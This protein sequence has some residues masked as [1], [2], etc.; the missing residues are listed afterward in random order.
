MHIVVTIVG[1]LVVFAVLLDA[2]ET[3]VLPRRVRR[4]YRITSWF[5]RRT[6][7]PWRKITTHIKT[8]S[9]RENFLG[10]FGPLSL[11][12]LLGLWAA[13]LIFGFALLQYGAGEHVQLSGEPITF[14]RLLYHSGETFFTLGYG[15][16]VPTSPIARLLAVLEAGM[17]FGF[18]GTVIG[19]LPTIYSAFSRREI[20]ISLLDARAG[21]P[22]TAAEL[23]GRFGNRPQQLEFDQILR[24]WERWA[25]EVLES[26]I[27]YPP[28]GFFR[29]Q[30]SNQSWLGALTTILDATALVIAGVDNLRSDQAKVTF[31][32]ARH[33]VV[34]LTQVIRTTYDPTH[35]D[36]LPAEELARLRKSL[37][38]RSVKLKEGPE[39]EEKLRHLRSLY[40]PYSQSV[41][42][43][44]L[45]TLPPWIH[46][47]KKKDNW[48][49]GPWDRAIQAKSLVIFGQANPLQPKVED[50]F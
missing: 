12:L 11:L 16:I 39:F 17:G 45:I 10:Y 18:L 24:E 23:L 36:R 30:H 35:P 20:Q 26:H 5:Y 19:Y 47:E 6:W 2:F 4:Q 13:T 38:D 37:A 41:A 9:R 7:V 31:A 28:L 21:S 27:S 8:P 42:R 3:V 34:D 49:A 29:S 14:G 33:A 48:E 50:H 25:G 43:T 46:P 15:D 1:I 22:P 40:E 32:M 44:L